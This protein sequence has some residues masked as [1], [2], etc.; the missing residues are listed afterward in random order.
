MFAHG[1]VHCGAPWDFIPHLYHFGTQLTESSSAGLSL[2][3]IAGGRGHVMTSVW[4][5]DQL[6]QVA[7][8]V[9]DFRVGSGNV[10]PAFYLEGEEPEISMC[11]GIFVGPDL[12]S[13]LLCLL[14]LELHRVSPLPSGSWSDLTERICWPKG[15]ISLPPFCG[16][17]IPTATPP[18][19]TSTPW[20][21]LSDGLW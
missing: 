7:Y 14:A 15:H 8:S 18:P 16:G 5:G 20:F 21:Q 3:I 11:W 1:H 12:F 2:V 13:V 17:C 19:S 6:K 9:L 4:K 10:G